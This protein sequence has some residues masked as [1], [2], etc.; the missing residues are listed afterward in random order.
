MCPRR[1]S[2]REASSRDHHKRN[3]NRML[4][5]KSYPR[6]GM[7]VRLPSTLM[8]TWLQED[9]GTSNHKVLPRGRGCHTFLI[10]GGREESNHHILLLLL[11]LC[12]HNIPMMRVAMSHQIN[13]REEVTEEVMRHGRGHTS[14]KNSRMEGRISLSLPTMDLLEKPTRCW[15]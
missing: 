8:V 11:S 10:Q 13:Q 6:R 5:V 14:S 3:T 7:E 4:R 2:S 1:K 9:S 12:H 15:L